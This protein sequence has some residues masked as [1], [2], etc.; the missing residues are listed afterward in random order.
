[1]DQWGKVDNVS[2]IITC[3]ES[4]IKVRN[5]IWTIIVQIVLPLFRI[6]RHSSSLAHHFQVY[7]ILGVKSTKSIHASKHKFFLKVNQA[8]STILSRYMVRK[9]RWNTYCTFM[10]LM[11]LYD[12][13][14]TDISGM[15]I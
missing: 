15:R 11:L 12:T 10:Q 13:V 7:F 5:K 9:R 14:C 4:F 2:D 1:M 8:G 3:K 6:R